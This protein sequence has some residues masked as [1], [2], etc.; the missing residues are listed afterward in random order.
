MLRKTDFDVFLKEYWTP[1]A[2]EAL[3]YQYRPFMAMCP[4]NTGLGGE[5]TVVP[6]DVDDGADGSATFSDAQAVAQTGG[7]D[8][9]RRQFQ[10][11]VVEDFQL[12]QIENKLIRLSRKSPELALQR[13]VEE[14]TKKKNILAARIA[15]DM[16]RS[17]YGE[18]GT[19]ST[20]VS[21]TSTKV[22][23]LSNKQDARNFRVGG[24]YVFASSLTAALRDGGDYVTATAIDYDNAKI[25]TDAPVDLATSITAI[26]DGD[27]I[28]VK[29]KRDVGSN[30]T[31]KTIQGLGA[32]IPSTAP[33]LGSDNFNGVD[34]GVW[35]DR[36]AG[37]RYQ[38]GVAQSGPIQEILINSLVDAAIREVY[39]SHV[40]IDASLYGQALLALEGTATRIQDEK[41][42]NGRGDK[43]TIGFQGFS[44]QIGYGNSGT[45][46]F[47][48]ANCPVKTHYALTLDRFKLGSAGELIQ[49][50]LQSGSNRDV[51]NASAVEYR[52]VF[53]GSFYTNA[54]GKQQ[55]VK[56]A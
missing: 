10:V 27:I 34:R 4:K 40:F 56:Y 14:T 16:Y 8:A 5:Y 42:T 21:A 53:C 32:W 26:A 22:I 54:P 18:I 12:A 13:A 35:P 46:V 3:T 37:L 39:P 28:F 36:L 9:L 23:G 48:D 15:R 49:N 43:T 30:P 38:A 24:R 11:Q 33:T 7:T 41:G 20:S 51:E 6:V 1:L 19:V 25:T 45:K 17:G 55:V 44:L 50:D 29:G 52:Y 47:P 31:L 2:E